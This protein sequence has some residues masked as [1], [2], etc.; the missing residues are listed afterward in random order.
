MKKQSIAVSVLILGLLIGVGQPSTAPNSPNNISGEAATLSAYN[1]SGSPQ[2][3][4]NPLHNSAS[5]AFDT[6]QY[7]N[8]IGTTVATPTGESITL[9]KYQTA[10]N[11]NDPY[12]NQ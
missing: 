6:V 3:D 4:I 10:I 9:K 5:T 2:I 11:V 7:K 1:P 8:R 12:A